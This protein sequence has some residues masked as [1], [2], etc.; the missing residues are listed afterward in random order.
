[1]YIHCSS[2][3]IEVIAPDVCQQLISGENISLAL[4]QKTQQLEFLIGKDHFFPGHMDLML[5]WVDPQSL[6]QPVLLFSS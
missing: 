2:L 5:G 3:S 4:Y 6:P 1:M